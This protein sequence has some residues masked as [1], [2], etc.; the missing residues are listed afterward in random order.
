MRA[1]F[2]WKGVIYMYQTTSLIHYALF[3]DK[4]LGGYGGGGVIL[5]LPIGVFL[6]FL[7]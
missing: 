5:V 7:Q 1:K 4:T 6:C 3:I 2:F